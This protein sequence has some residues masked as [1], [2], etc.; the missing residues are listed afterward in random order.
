MA[1]F[2][3]EYVGNTILESLIREIGWIHN[4]AI[5]KKCKDD[6]QRQFYIAATK[7]F[8]WTV[9]VLGH[10]IENKSFEKYLTNQTNFDKTVPAHIKKQALLAVKDH[11]TFDFIELSDEHSEH[12]L[13]EALIKNI[14]RFLIEVGGDFTFVGNQY[15]I[16]VDDEDFFID[17]LLFNRKIQALVAIE[18][19]IG[20]FKP[21]YKG[22][23]EFY[24]EALN[25]KTRLPHENDSIGIIICKNKKRTIVEYS[26]RNA[27]K[28]IGVATY[29]T[30]TQLPLK[31]RA[32]LP[33]SKQ[34]AEQINTF[35]ENATIE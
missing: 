16:T 12:E 1:Q 6:Q 23:M 20:N 35:M 34:I 29:S 7:K 5:F 24:L 33:G 8:G 17:L 3:D 22:K 4:I 21:E 10:Q 30:S 19:K 26:L 11:Y 9:S 15:K 18:L 27:A 13:E 32:I 25:E 28:P 14:R 2:Y 31:Y